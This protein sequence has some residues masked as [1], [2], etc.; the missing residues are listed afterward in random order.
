[1]TSPQCNDPA[2]EVI[3]VAMNAM[4]QAFDP[5]SECPPLGGGT[6]TVRLFAGSGDFPAAWIRPGGECE[7]PLLWVRAAHRYRSRTA[8]FPT[9]FVG[10][11]GCSE[12]GELRRVLAVEVGVGRCISVDADPDWELLEDEATNSLDDSWRIETVLKAIV[13][14]LRS[15]E[16][17][18]AT[19]TVAPFGP[20]GGIV[21]WTGMAY[22]QF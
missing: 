18:V 22:V 11:I 19:D 3:S 12:Y 20:E 9:A 17:A 21:A 8:Q 1:M 4:S 2:W 13:C 5:A 16:R 14:R 10:D 15:N 6:T 7:G